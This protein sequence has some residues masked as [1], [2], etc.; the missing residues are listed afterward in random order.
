MTVE[1]LVFSA[2]KSAVPLSANPFT[3]ARKVVRNINLIAQLT[4]RDVSHRYRNSF[5]GLAWTFITPFFW[6]ALYTFVFNII[7]KARWGTGA[8]GGTTE[9]A[10][11]LFCGLILYGVFSEGVMQSPSL[12]TSNSIYVK[13]IHFPLELLPIISL[14]H[15]LIRAFASLIILAVVLLLVNGTLPWTLVFFPLPFIPII[16]YTVGVML[17]FSALGVFIRDLELFVPFPV[18]LLFFLTPIVYPR[19]C[20]PEKYG[21]LMDFNPFAHLVDMM[22]NLALNCQIGDWS[23]YGINLVLSLFVFQVGLMF[24]VKCKNGFADVM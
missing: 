3:F 16:I 2:Q 12:I 4:R 10:M 18:Q 9:F 5:L 21:W 13:K 7:L 20:I 1:Y 24:F 6:L 19:S 11:Y 23:W 17:L 15:L 22:R 14:G 8:Q